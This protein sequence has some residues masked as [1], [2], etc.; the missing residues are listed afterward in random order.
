MKWDRSDTR[1][2]ATEM[3]KLL[4]ATLVLMAV[5][6]AIIVGFLTAVWWFVS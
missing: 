2:V 5:S 1:W 3:G 6:T 4:L